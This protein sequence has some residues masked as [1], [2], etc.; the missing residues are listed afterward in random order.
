M[1]EAIVQEELKRLGTKFFESIIEKKINEALAS[2]KQQIVIEEVKQNQ[3][4]I[5]EPIIKAK[6]CLDFE[7]I[8]QTKLNQ[9]EPGQII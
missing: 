6:N 3:L 4:A 7:L 5:N 9:V 8:T 1:I 2:K